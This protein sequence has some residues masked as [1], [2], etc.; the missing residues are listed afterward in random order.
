MPPAFRLLILL[1]V[2]WTVSSCV[3]HQELISFN[4]TSR[5]LDQ[6][7]TIQN[8]YNLVIQPEDLLRITVHSYD[9]EA[10][11][12]FNLDQQGNQNNN[13]MM[14]Q[15]GLQG[16]NSLELFTGFFV[17]HQGYIDYPVLGRIEVA[18][19]TLEEAKSRILLLLEK[20]LKDAVVNI[21]YL[22]L[23]ITV[24]GEVNAPG[25]VR[26]SNRRVTLLEALGMAGDLTPYA[27]RRTVLLIREEN[28]HRTYTR[29][30][31]QSKKIFDSPYF[32]LQQ[33]D[34][35]YVEPIRAKIATVAD[36]AQRI[37]G[38]SSGLLSIISIILAISR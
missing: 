4:E 16:A 33:N 38:Y 5:T 7:D 9:P 34:V 15:G 24:L 2:V 21:R 11:A 26:L 13:M 27:N 29:I 22:N 25:M 3:S 1:F 30:N 10:A 6:Q 37:I 8:P 35:I 19:L 12:P 28:S 17:D 18:G 32:Y 20:Y 14:Q 36:P 23:K 31:L